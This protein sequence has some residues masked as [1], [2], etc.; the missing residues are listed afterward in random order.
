MPRTLHG[1]RCSC[2]FQVNNMINDSDIIEHGSGALAIFKLT[3][4][5][6][7]RIS[8]NM[9]RSGAIFIFNYLV[10]TIKA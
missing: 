4:R 10:R 6:M 5:Q 2:Q 8:L 1:P 7:T 9:D 3:I